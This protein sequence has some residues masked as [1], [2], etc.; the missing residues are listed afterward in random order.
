MAQ[1]DL[2]VTVLR[3]NCPAPGL[4]FQIKYSPRKSRAEDPGPKAYLF[5]LG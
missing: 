5:R 2:L 3:D 4:S 1:S